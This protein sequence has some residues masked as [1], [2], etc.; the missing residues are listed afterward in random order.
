MITS[1]EQTYWLA[2]HKDN[3]QCKV[4]KWGYHSEKFWYVQ[5]KLQ[6]CLLRERERELYLPQHCKNKQQYKW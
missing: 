4:A 1:Q 6:E 3:G 2:S 5:G